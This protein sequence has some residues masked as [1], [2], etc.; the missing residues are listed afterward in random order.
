MKYAIITG[1]SSG[2]GAAIAKELQELGYGLVLLARRIDRLEE[3][4][5]KLSQT[6]VYIAQLDVCQEEQVKNVIS[7][8]PREIAENCFILVNNAGLAVGRGPLDTGLSEDWNRMLDTNVKGLLYMSH[9]VI[10]LLKKHPYSHL[11]N[12]SSI[13]G[14]E[15]YAGGNVY[16]ASKHAVDA[17]SKALRI[18]LLPHQIKV[19]NIAPGAAE[20]EFSLVRFKGDAQTAASVYDGFAALQAIDIAQTVAFIVSRPAHV[21]IA[22]V[23]IMPTAQANGSLFHKK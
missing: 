12:I 23:T 6:P 9:A 14:K 16:C 4:Q 17:L 1:A 10:P 19:S 2:F 20:T 18:D 22:D 21:S 7:N 11:I 5:K 13:A 3:L 15:V 8:L